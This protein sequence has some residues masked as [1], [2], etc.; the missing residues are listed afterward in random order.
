MSI[1]TLDL[2]LLLVLD[3]VLSERSVA[4]AARRLHV[5][6]S[7]VSNALARLRDA[8]G[9]PLVVRRG[10][11]IAP[12]PRAIELAPA[13]TRALRDLERAVRGGAFD[14]ATTTR[15]FTLALADVGQI[16][17]LPRIAALV[18]AEMPRALLRVVGVDSLVS[19]GG[20]AGPE[21]D[22]AF[23]VADRGPGVHAEALFDE[24]TTLVARADHEAVRCRVSRAG[25][26]ALRHVT[27]EM[28]PGRAIRDLVAVSYARAGIAR[29]VVMTVP[30]FTAAAAVVAATD[31]VATIPSSLLEALGPR[32]GLRAVAASAPEHKVMMSL[33]WHDRTDA[34][35]AL[36]AFRDLVRRGLAAGAGPAREGR[37]RASRRRR[38]R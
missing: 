32:M 36:V 38:P 12:T 37:L 6:P 26:E 4:R 33:S 3:T 35:P 20:L 21:I 17:R 14:A 5:T 31:Y 27:V 16:V 2:N 10:R 25:L 29:E 13:L 28:A 8:L 7:A 19:L 24:P 22:V 11:G 18:A 30:S 23:G 15:R 9:D 34:D 1:S